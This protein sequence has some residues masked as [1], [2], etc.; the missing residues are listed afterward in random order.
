L[1][2]WFAYYREVILTGS[3]LSS[4][5]EGKMAEWQ[6]VT[7]AGEVATFESCEA[8]LSALVERQDDFQPEPHE[9]I[10]VSEERAADA[11][12]D[13]ARN[14]AIDTGRNTTIAIPPGCTNFPAGSNIVQVEVTSLVVLSQ[15]PCDQ[16]GPPFLVE[17]P[18][19]AGVATI[20]AVPAAWQSTVRSAL[21]WY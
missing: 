15:Y 21:T 9:A 16:F 3:V 12:G 1:L 2:R 13:T 10:Q 7:T 5:G 20:R 17:W 6:A 19:A 11:A 4:E 18:T 14:R 8:L